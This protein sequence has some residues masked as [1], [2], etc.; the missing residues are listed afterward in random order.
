MTIL[1]NK[2]SWLLHYVTSGT[3]SKE[4]SFA[5]VLIHAGL[6]EKKR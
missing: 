2:G 6:A 1:I 4:D 5:L 3:K